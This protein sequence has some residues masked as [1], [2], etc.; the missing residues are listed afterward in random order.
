[1]CKQCDDNGRVYKELFPGVL[2]FE[3]CTCE[4]AEQNMRNFKKR[5]KAWRNQ[6]NAANAKFS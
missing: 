3:A 1:M 5:M 2:T 4:V 6:I